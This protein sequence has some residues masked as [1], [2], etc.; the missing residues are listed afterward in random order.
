MNK[1][2]LYVKNLEGSDAA[3]TMIRFL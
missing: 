2:F 1:R 3:K